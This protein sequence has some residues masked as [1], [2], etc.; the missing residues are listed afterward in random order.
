MILS[1]K[2]IRQA[3]DPLYAVTVERIY[4]GLTN[5]DSPLATQVQRLRT[6]Q[7]IDPA[8]FRRLKT[9]L[10]YLVC[11]LFH[12]AVRRREHFVH[13]KCLFLDFDHVAAAD[14]TA[15]GVRDRIAADPRV[16]LA[17]ASPGND[18]VK[19]LFTLSQ[20][21]DDPAYFSACYKA[22]AIHFARS[23]RL[24]TL[25]DLK[26]CDV[27]RCCFMSHDPDAYHYPDAE[28]IIAAD[29]L[30][31]EGFR[32][33]DAANRA[34]EQ[35][36]AEQQTF[37]ATNPE[38]APPKGPGDA[39]MALI[40]QKLLANTRQRA[41]ANPIAQPE[42]LDGLV[43][44]AAEALAA[45]DMSLAEATPIAYG[46]KLK[47]VAGSLWAEINLFVGKKGVTLV[48]TTKTGS[49]PDLAIAAAAMLRSHF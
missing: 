3:N 12:P 38:A 27:S 35:L 21:I 7:T 49:H 20:P 17:F 11:G 44:Q 26:T 30:P 2:N 18:G 41:P 10:P 33:L 29:Y 48:P 16:M 45:A 22:F 23:H 15:G 5:A 32:A 37:R 47:V 24:E 1:G 6:I 8:Q 40:R 46:R 14:L 13:T 42:A 39:A 25:V 28:A 36:M 4:K 9:E 43:K 31:P 34:A 19:A